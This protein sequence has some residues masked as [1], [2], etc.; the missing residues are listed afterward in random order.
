M[1]VYVNELP[2]DCLDCPCESE[3]CCNLLYED[4]GC[5]K[6]G[7]RHENC[8]LKLLSN[9]NKQ[10]KN[11]VIQEIWREFENQLINKTKDMSVMQVANMIN[12]VLDKIKGE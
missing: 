3:Y 8:P 1:T 5:L 4:V 11:E 9:Y 2:E 6:L 10:I 7:E 12:S